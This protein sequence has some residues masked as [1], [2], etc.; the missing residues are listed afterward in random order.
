[1][2]TESWT[3]EDLQNSELD[4]EGNILQRKDRIVGEKVRSGG[5][6]LYIKSALNAAVRE[7]LASIIFPE[8]IWCYVKIENE[9]TLIGICYRCTS[10]N[11][12]SNESLF[13]LISRA[14]F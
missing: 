6:M 4:I 12:L 13:E 7:D 11:K 14:S 8:C 9:N 5:V 1:M 10:S 2:R 3:F